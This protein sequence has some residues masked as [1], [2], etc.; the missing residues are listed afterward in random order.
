MTYNK[1]SDL[2]KSSGRQINRDRRNKPTLE[3]AV[4][5]FLQKITPRLK[6]FHNDMSEAENR[7]IEARERKAQA[8]FR[9]VQAISEIVKIA[10][11]QKGYKRKHTRK[12]PKVL[13]DHQKQVVRIIAER[14]NEGETL[15]QIAAYLREQDIPTLSGRGKWH[16][17]TAH[18]L[19]NGKN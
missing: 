2:Y 8:E 19:L 14:R 9:T 16:A 18:R 17:Q 10:K 7:I 4:S 1:K 11:E 5:N 3:D 15:E 12:S 6:Q 13:N